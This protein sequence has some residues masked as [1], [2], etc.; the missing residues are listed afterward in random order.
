MSCAI[1][2]YQHFMAFCENSGSEHFFF[3]M[4]VAYGRPFTQ[5]YKLG[6]ITCEYP[7]YPDFTDKDLNLRHQRMVDIRNKF[8]AHSSVEGTR[9][10]LV[11]PGVFNPVT[12]ETSEEFDHNIGKRMFRDPRFSEWLIE[13]A[14]AFKGRLDMDVR[15]QLRKEFSFLSST[16]IVEL[17]TGWTDFKWT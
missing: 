6:P 11:P 1:D 10:M 2:A 15:R 4:V 9:I 13:V 17:E 12:E 3:A 16:E 5:S 8:L 7:N 14:I